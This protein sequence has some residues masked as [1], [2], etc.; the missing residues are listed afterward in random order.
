[1]SAVAAAT[2]SRNGGAARRTRTRI[3]FGM[4]DRRT[5]LARRVAELSGLFFDAL[6]GER[7][8]NAVTAAAVGRASSLVACAEL[9]RCA[10]MAGEGNIDD[11]VR[12]ENAAD[13][14]VRRLGIAPGRKTRVPPLSRYL[15]GKR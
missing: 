3:P 7:S 11:V 8:V 1:M 15:P 4:I 6:G 14:A 2:Q 10:F 5:R 12:A 9:A 13:R